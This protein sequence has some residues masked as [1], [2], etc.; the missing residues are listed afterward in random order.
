MQIFDWQ[1][2]VIIDDC[3]FLE[4]LYLIFFIS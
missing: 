4:M 3:A 2:A 1:R